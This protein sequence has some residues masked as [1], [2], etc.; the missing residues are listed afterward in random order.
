MQFASEIHRYGS[1]R[2]HPDSQ[3]DPDVLS[4]MKNELLLDKLFSTCYDESRSKAVKEN[5][6]AIPAVQ[7]RQSG[8]KAAPCRC[9]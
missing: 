3:K 5:T 9:R 6:S 2:K 4:M 8:L 7:R 1:N